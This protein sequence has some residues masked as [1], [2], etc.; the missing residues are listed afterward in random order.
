MEQKVKNMMVSC[1][2]ENT[3]VY[4]LTLSGREIEKFFQAVV[5]ATPTDIVECRDD[6]L[7]YYIIDGRVWADT[8]EL[9]KRVREIIA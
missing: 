3:L 2:C 1:E 8:P 6:E 5:H 7:Q 9:E 4:C